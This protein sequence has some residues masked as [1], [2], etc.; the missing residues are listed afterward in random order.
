M[1][2][3]FSENYLQHADHFT[4]ILNERENIR[5]EKFLEK[6]S[7]SIENSQ[8]N[9]LVVSQDNKENKIN[10][11]LDEKDRPVQRSAKSDVEVN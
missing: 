11:N 6:R 3:K 10:E 7:E 1:E 2:T 8:D 9:S 4:R 5:R